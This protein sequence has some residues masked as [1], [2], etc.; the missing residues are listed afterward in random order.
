MAHQ[1]QLSFEAAPV[2]AIQMVRE[3]EV[4]YNAQKLTAPADAA[5]AFNALV[6]DPD[7][8]NF[9][10]I[11]LNGKNKII[12]LHVVSQGSLNQ[13]VVHPRETFKA[14]ILANA[15]GIILAHNHPSGD[16]APSQED[17][18][19]T[20]RLAE[21]GELLGIKVLDHVVVDTETGNYLSFVEEGLL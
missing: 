21:A 15:A 5:S 4:L 8:E 6:G 16:T 11:M 13:S 18:A 3:R 1:Q 14:A 12:G 20:K 9:A 19:V 2:F 10:V 7:R 17:K